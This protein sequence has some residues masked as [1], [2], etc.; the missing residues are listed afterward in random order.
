MT[1]HVSVLQGANGMALGCL[2]LSAPERINAQNLAMVRQMAAALSAWQ[3]ADDI[4]AIVIIGAGERG[5]CAGGD[6]KALYEAMTEPGQLAAGDDFFREEYQLCHHLRH[7]PKPV[8]AWGHGIIMGGG[9]GVF[10]AASHRVVTPGTR[11]AMPETG[12]GLFPDV[13]ASWWLPRLGDGPSLGRVLGLTGVPIQAADALAV[14]AAQYLLPAADRHAVLTALATQPWQAAAAENHALLSDFLQRWPQAEGAQ[15]LDAV[16]RAALNSATAADDLSAVLAAIATWAGSDSP[17]CRH[18]AQ[19]LAQA[20][21]TSVWLSWTLQQRAA[22]QTLAQTVALETALA[23]AAL[24]YGDFQAG[25]YSTLYA[26]GEA[27]RWQVAALFSEPDA[28]TAAQFA[29]LWA[30]NTCMA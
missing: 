30:E 19:R 25:I 3:D 29:A 10:A 15:V 7:Y 8:L 17:W 12:I 6:L 23:A 2:A 20:S 16:T 4:A 1:V 11:L 9:W 26:R 13:S 22:Q 27:P 5:F 24:R 21:P 14:G 28:T 18:A